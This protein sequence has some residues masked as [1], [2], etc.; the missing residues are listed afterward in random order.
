MKT[1][2]DVTTSPSNWLLFKFL[3]LLSSTDSVGLKPVTTGNIWKLPSEICWTV[4]VL[5]FIWHE[6]WINLVELVDVITWP[7]NVWTRLSSHFWVV[8][9]FNVYFLTRLHVFNPEYV[10]SGNGICILENMIISMMK[11]DICNWREKNQRV[12]KVDFH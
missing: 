8:L 6:I 3:F 2:D 1:N 9:F 10:A 5:S 7:G 11:F 12:C 4:Y